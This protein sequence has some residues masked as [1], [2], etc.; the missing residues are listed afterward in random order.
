MK[1]WPTSENSAYH[2]VWVGTQRKLL[3][4]S[5]MLWFSRCDF[6]KFMAF[7]KSATIFWLENMLLLCIECMCVTKNISHHFVMQIFVYD[8]SKNR[9]NSRCSNARR[10]LSLVPISTYCKKA[11]MKPR[12]VGVT[13]IIFKFK[14][15]SLIGLQIG[16]FYYT[17]CESC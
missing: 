3:V 7:L 1:D 9:C 15:L 8:A 12:L 17:F 14:L 13:F 4:T 10:C 5:R 11:Q 16:L 2:S 6:I